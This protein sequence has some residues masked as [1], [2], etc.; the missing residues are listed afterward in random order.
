MVHLVSR[1]ASFFGLLG[2]TA[3]ILK[4]EAYLSYVAGERGV[5]IL[6]AA[7]VKKTLHK[8]NASIG[9]FILQEVKLQGLK[10]RLFLDLYPFP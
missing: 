7:S 2:C 6:Y 1:S 10:E 8:K 3:F 5:S 9:M 4:L